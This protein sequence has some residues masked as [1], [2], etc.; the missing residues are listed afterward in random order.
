MREPS[1]SKFMTRPSSWHIPRH[2]HISGRVVATDRITAYE[3]YL[4]KLSRKTRDAAD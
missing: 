3:Y 2:L 1:S 4:A